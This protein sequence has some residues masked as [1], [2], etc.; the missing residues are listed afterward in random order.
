MK[1]SSQNLKC[2]QILDKLEPRN[3][4]GVLLLREML[5]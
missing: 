1:D 3:W 2:L 4:G 5:K